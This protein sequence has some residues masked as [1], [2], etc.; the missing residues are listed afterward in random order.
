M[1]GGGFA[2]GGFAAK[3]PQGGRY[4]GNHYAGVAGNRGADDLLPG[5]KTRAKSGHEFRAATFARKI[6]AR[7]ARIARHGDGA[8][9]LRGGVCVAADAGVPGAGPV[10]D[11]DG[12]RIAVAVSGGNCGAPDH[13]SGRV[14][15]E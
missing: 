1:A 7:A 8:E 5:S 11:D 2:A 15:A 3:I 14:T 9:L 4:A 12:V 13:L 10:G 6:D